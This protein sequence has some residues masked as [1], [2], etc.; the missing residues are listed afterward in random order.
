MMAAI[1]VNGRM[2]QSIH[3]ELAFL[4]AD[5]LRLIDRALAEMSDF[6]EV[7]LVK[8][9]GKLRFIQK[10]ESEAL[11]GGYTGPPD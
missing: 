11:S 6:G 7:R 8:A 3:V 1:K 9:K 10:L 4:E 2:N 5:Q